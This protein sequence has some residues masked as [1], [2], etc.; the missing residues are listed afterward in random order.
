MSHICYTGIGARKS[1]EHTKKQFLNIMNK[2]SKIP[3]KNKYLTKRVCA[4]YIQSLKCKSCKKH[5]RA[6]RYMLKKSKKYPNYR[7]SNK[8]EN[9]NQKLYNK[10]IKCQ[11]NTKI[12]CDLKDFIK[13]SGAN[14]GKCKKQNN[15]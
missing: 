3:W 12:I 1:G 5:K 4:E 10:C 15:L 6:F 9:K 14:V 7:Q 11:T 8:H 2:K 13:Y